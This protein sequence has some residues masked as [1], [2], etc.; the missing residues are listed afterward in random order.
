MALA[1]RVRLAWA[2]APLPS[3]R[4]LA[5]RPTPSPQRGRR[6]AVAFP[7][8]PVLSSP[9]TLAQERSRHYTIHNTYVSDRSYFALRAL[10]FEVFVN[11]HHWL[12]TRSWGVSSSIRGHVNCPATCCGCE[13]Q[14]ER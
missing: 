10:R 9:G 5:G 6:G 13:G 2:L 8:A 7:R 11:G 14:C 1:F 4:L 12:C 3:P